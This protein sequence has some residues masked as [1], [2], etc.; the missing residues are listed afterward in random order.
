MDVLN[1]TTTTNTNTN[2]ICNSITVLSPNEEPK[3]QCEI[4]MEQQQQQPSTSRSTPVDLLPIGSPPPLRIVPDGQETA[5]LT[6]HYQIC[7]LI[8]KGPICTVYRAL[9]RSTG[10]SHTVKS[11]DLKRFCA[12]SGL[13]QEDAE[14]EVEICASLKHPY[15]VQLND[16]IS[17]TNALHMVFEW[18]DGEDLCF[19]IVRRAAAGFIYSEAVASHYTRQLVEA[20]RYMHSLD[21]VHR[22]IRPHNLLLANKENNA[23]LK[24]RGLALAHRLHS[25]TANCPAGRI[26]VPQF[27]APEIVAGKE[28]GKAVDMWSVG[29]ILYVLLCGQMPFV[30]KTGDVFQ[31]ISGGHYSMSGPIWASISDTAKDLLRQLLCVDPNKRTTPEK[32]L[33]HDWFKKSVPPRVHLGDTIENIR[34]FNARRR[35]KS[36]IVSSVNNARLNNTTFTTTTTTISNSNSNLVPKLL[37][38][39]PSSSS[40]Y[41]GAQSLPGGDSCDFECLPPPINSSNNDGAIADGQQNRTEIAGV[42]RVLTSLDQISVLTD[43]VAGVQHQQ[44]LLDQALND[45]E[46]HQLLLRRCLP[47]WHVRV[48]AAAEKMMCRQNL[49]QQQQQQQH[50]CCCSMHC[51]SCCTHCARHTQHLRQKVCYHHH[52]QQQLNQ[53]KQ[54]PHEEELFTVLTLNYEVNGDTTLLSPKKN[55]DE[56]P[57]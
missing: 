24:V 8:E 10:R 36:N 22:D 30:G 48:C 32:C 4:I 6:H 43:C 44:Q 50:A 35:L 27:M 13:S 20:V 21:I 14:K 41:F 25:D 15:F 33:R 28:Y 11:L 42:E 54:K 40:S 23:P 5:L 16:V 51:C 29:V 34:R 12:I 57:F 45:R 19:E 3:C 7:D 1:T 9:H 18:V 2:I 49:Q 56:S 53:Q 38:L 52:K 55:G 47:A 39:S 26:G 46:L 37:A 31:Q 17:G